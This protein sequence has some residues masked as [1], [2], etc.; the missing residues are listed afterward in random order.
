MKDH[1]KPGRPDFILF[2][3]VVILVG[4]GLVMV[5]S[6]SSVQS[7]E[8]YDDSGFIFFKQ[9]M[10]MI[11]GLLGLLVT[12][13]LPHHFYRRKVVM[14]LAVAVVTGLLVGVIFQFEANGA[15]RWY[16]IAGF[17]FQPSDLAKIV[18]IM[19]IAAY[20]TAFK[21]G[22]G[23]WFR[24]LRY[25][26]PV[27]AIF[28]GL[29]LMQ[30]DFGTTMI[31]IFIAGIMLFLAGLPSRFLILG[32]ILLL[33]M[34]AG[35][36]VTKD[37]RMQ[38]LKAYFTEEHYQ[39]RQ[40]KLAIGSG[41]LTGLGMGNGEQ[42]L[43]YLPEPH[44]DFIFATLCEEFGFIGASA[45]LMCYMFLLLRGVFVLQRVDD[46]Y[47]R[48]LGAGLLMLL[49]VQAFIN[50]SI[51]VGLFPNKGL[52]LPFISAGGTSLAMSLCMFGILLNISR[53]QVIEN[54]MVA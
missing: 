48:L 22:P 41:G 45:L 33:P 31:I 39:N 52:T 11:G 6:A 17:G 12:L 14:Y 40:A 54:R 13:L 29:I 3:P 27:L 16:N 32:A 51:A 42:K 37:Y 28:C 46:R 8:L 30:P 2:I 49:I 53:F 9:A 47:S 5:H 36:V 34:V 1:R 35:L 25:I 15:R 10:A 4:L 50:I 44:T 21:D 23:A 38:R 7:R 20:A 26:I 24:R 43:H 18:L 19:F